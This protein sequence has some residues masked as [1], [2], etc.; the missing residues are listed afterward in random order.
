MRVG[1]V[2]PFYDNGTLVDYLNRNPDINPLQVVRRSVFHPISS[3]DVSTCFKL[4]GVAE[5]VAYLHFNKIVHGDLRGVSI[6]Q[7][8]DH[9]T[10]QTQTRRPTS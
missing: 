2:S 6:L 7:P 10:A 1:M 3:A 8:A 9:R 5:G 4:Q